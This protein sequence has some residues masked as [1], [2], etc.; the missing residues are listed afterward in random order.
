[1]SS[2]FPDIDLIGQPDFAEAL[3]HLAPNAVAGVDLLVIYD[4]DYDFLAKV[5]NA[6]GFTDPKVEVHLLPWTAEQGGIDLARLIR[7]LQVKRVILF[8]QDL[9]ALGLHFHVA[10]YFPVA[11]AGVTYLTTPSVADI[12]SAKANGDNGPAGALWRAVKAG[13]LKEQ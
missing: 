12:A 7:H 3:R 5:L 8:G 9:V 10:A 2:L 4:T 11:V 13:F 6:A 1:M